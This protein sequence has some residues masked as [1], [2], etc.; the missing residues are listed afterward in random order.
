MG[1]RYFINTDTRELKEINNSTLEHPLGEGWVEITKTDYEAKKLI[2]YTS[3]LALI[4]A[5]IIQIGGL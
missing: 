5:A 4:G 1:P 3:G 2:V